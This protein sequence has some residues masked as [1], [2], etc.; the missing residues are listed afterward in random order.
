MPA[1][2]KGP[3]L[4]LDPR[5]KQW[6][7]RHGQRFIRTGCPEGDDQGAEEALHQYLAHSRQPEPS[8]S[9]L[10]ADVLLVY[11][12]E[13]APHT[14]SIVTIAQN[15]ANLE[16]W[17][18]DKKLSD[19]TARTCRAY[20]AERPPVAARRDL[21]TLRAAIGY[22]HKEYG[23]LPS[24][25][26]VV[27]PEK[28]APRERWLTRSEVARLL[29]AARRT[30]HLAR[31]ILLGAYTGSRPGTILAL[32]WDWVDLARGVMHRR[33]EGETES[34]KRRPPVRLGRKILFHLR[35]WR[36]MDNGS[37]YVVNLTGITFRRYWK[38]A[39]ERSGLDGQIT[40]H[41]LRHSRATHLMQAGV[42]IWEA[43]GAL[44]MSAQVLEATYGHHHVDYQKQAA[45]V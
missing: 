27:L 2:S 26:A 14:R 42:P 23:P 25:P 33:A 30:P 4:Y 19:V 12:R 13:H 36:R 43:A 18:G 29:W 1:R 15:I 5:R 6:V 44:G 40:P 20:T 7:I 35:R 28:P 17:W 11:G 21:E 3:R 34:N 8:P 38:A 31:F 39:V 45:E 32:Q 22:W 16:R 24:V 10:I 9:P 41:T 37:A